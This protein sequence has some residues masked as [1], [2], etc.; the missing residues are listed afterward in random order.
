MGATDEND[1]KAGFSNYGT[2]VT[3]AA[4]GKNILSCKFRSNEFALKK[5]YFY[6]SSSCVWISSLILSKYPGISFSD[7]IRKLRNMLI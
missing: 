6:G 3:V 5:W 4:P 1:N 2:M 7:L